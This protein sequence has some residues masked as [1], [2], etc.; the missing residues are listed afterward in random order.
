[1]GN[2][3]ASRLHVDFIS[4]LPKVGTNGE[5]I[6]FGRVL[7]GG[8]FLKT[9]QVPLFCPRYRGFVP[10]PLP[11]SL[12]EVAIVLLMEPLAQRSNEQLWM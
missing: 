6:V 3:L 9:L 8:R 4:E 1:M 11:I 10:H 12:P 7:G 2:Q 5:G